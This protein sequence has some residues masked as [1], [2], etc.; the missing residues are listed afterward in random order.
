MPQTNT[1]LFNTGG[2]NGAT[3]FTPGFK[4]VPLQFNS[5]PWNTSPWNG[6][7]VAQEPGIEQV[8]LFNTT[9]IDLVWASVKNANAYQL[10]VSLFADFRTT[11]LDVTADES[12]HQ[13]TDSATNNVK[14]Y[15][16]WKPSTD[17]GTTFSEPYSEV[18][19]YW[20]DT[21]A[22]QQISLDR[23]QWSLTD[24]DTTTDQYIFRLF[25]LFQITDENLFRI[26]ERNRLGELLSEFLTIKGQVTLMFDGSQY[27]EHPQRNEFVRFHNIVRV[28][29]LAVFKDGER[30][31]AMSNIWKAEFV[32]DP[33]LI[34]I[35]AGRQDLL[36]GQIRFTEV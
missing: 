8:I 7:A 19:S 15:W 9:S 31:R 1:Q 4:H 23:G 24:P 25:P 6:A 33:S 14:R 16:R 10:Q 28:V 18:G 2:W 3:S 22:A 27:M 34:M 21:G 32:D 29:F 20:L 36:T 5:C 35:A 26:Q 12:D 30:E 13:F 11:I 17:G